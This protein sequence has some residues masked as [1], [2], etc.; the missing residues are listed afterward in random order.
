MSLKKCLKKLGLEKYEETIIRS[1]ARELTQ[2]GIDSKA[3]AIQAVQ[4]RLDVYKKERESIVSQIRDKDG[5]LP[6]ETFYQEEKIKG[7]INKI[8]DPD[9]KQ[10][11]ETGKPVEFEYIRNT[12][13]APAMGARFQQD[14]E[15]VGRYMTAKSPGAKA[16]GTMEVGTVKFTSPLI[17][18][19]NTEKD[20]GYDETG[21]K[22]SLSKSFGGLTG[23]QLSNAIKNSGYD[24]VVTV[25]KQKSGQQYVS[26][27][28]DLT[29]P[30]TLYQS[31][32]EE[33]ETKLSALHNLSSENLLHADEL[34]GLALPSIAVVPEDVAVEGYGDVTLIGTRELGDPKEVP[35]FDAD[36]Y[37]TTFPHPE[38]SKVKSS[39]AQK[40]IDDM[41]DVSEEFEDYQSL[42]LLWDHM[43]NRPAPEDAINTMLRSFTARVSFLKEQGAEVKPSIQRVRREYQWANKEMSDALDKYMESGYSDEA[44][45]AVTK[46]ARES[47]DK[48][49]AKNT[50]V[51]EGLKEDLEYS[52][53]DIR[54]FY[55]SAFGINGEWLTNN[56]LIPFSLASK[57]QDD[58][59]KAGKK[60][61]N[62]RATE[63]KINKALKGKEEEF[64]SWLEDKIIPLYGD[65]FL[66]ISRKKES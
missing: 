60:E 27:I 5:V 29:D 24:A 15:P 17:V 47:I 7:I 39:K 33:Q 14:I 30:K 45:L 4:N 13:R 8:K 20:G 61:V 11:F 53:D 23:I 55:A 44:G 50:K 28:V 46:V 10:T 32:Q 43:V 49:I 66:R 21:W 18:E 37:T 31:A 3:A 65:P 16:I 54:Q 57:I 34:G 26:E 51:T 6:T 42:S 38:Y 9:S 63:K 64:K 2:E 1:E 36:A 48:Y 35:V 56:E 19:W 40:I 41:R 62:T 12:E 58:L 22:A 52:D 59:G 25:S